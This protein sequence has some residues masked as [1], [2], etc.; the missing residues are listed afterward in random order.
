VHG[1]KDK[2]RRATNLIGVVHR[3]ACVGNLSNVSIPTD[4]FLA[5]EAELS[6]VAA[7]G[8]AGRFET[9]QTD[10][11][12]PVKLATLNGILTGRDYSLEGSF[13]S[14]LTR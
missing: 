11:V 10:G 8:P 9:V 4:F 1:T 5:E 2:T 12:D 13:V 14:S 7:G 6:L 3:T